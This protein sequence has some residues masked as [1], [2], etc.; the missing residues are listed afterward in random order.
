M[1]C[2]PFSR[3]TKGYPV[4]PGKIIALGINYR[5]HMAHSPTLNSPGS[6][7]PA[8]PVI[9]PKAPSC[10]TGPGAPII[11]PAFIKDYGFSA[12]R[13]DM[14]GELAFII[15]D[16]CKNVS[17]EEAY[18][19]I[20]GFCCFNDVSQRNLQTGDKA[21]WFR[22]KSLDTFGPLGPVLVAP[23][24]MPDPQNL[25]IVSR[26]NGRV[27]QEGS[28][29]DMIF[30]IRD[31]LSFVSRWFTLM[32]GDIISTGTPGGVSPLAPGDLCEVE[33]EGIGVLA[34]PVREETP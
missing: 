15:R 25:R 20:L 13:T 24:D 33:I 11:L 6:P 16:R 34:N 17:P 5:E 23:E 3:N 9:F 31:I 30:S 7:L 26:L 27:V 12:P 18:D 19:H 14:E 10:L 22:G 29:E 28:T 4:N 2:L 21:G 32:P 1:I 8:E